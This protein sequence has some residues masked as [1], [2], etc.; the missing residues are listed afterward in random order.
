MANFF[1]K[2]TKGVNDGLATVSENSKI[3]VEKTKLNKQIHDLDKEQ[4][5]LY[6][7]MGI[8]AFNL[9]N[10]G[11][12]HIEQCEEICSEINSREQKKML[13][14]QE[15]EALEHS[16]QPT[17]YSTPQT[18]VNG[19]ECICGHINPESNNFC[20]MCGQPLD[21]TRI[22]N[23]IRCTCGHT[24]KSTNDFCVM[25]GQPLNTDSAAEQGEE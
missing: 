24:N 8:L 15:I 3:I 9:Q 1:T 19:T 2:M 25:C 22:F 7:N 14:K 5:L 17:D 16:N 13:L 20:V 11:V 10:D 21:K 12:I 6:T 4:E 18:S 23:G